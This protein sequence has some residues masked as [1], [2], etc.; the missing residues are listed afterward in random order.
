[1]KKVTEHIRDSLLKTAEILIEMAP[2]RLAVT[3]W[4][5]QFEKLMRNRL[6]MGALRYGRMC[7]PRPK[8]IT[9][10]HM[11]IIYKRLDIY[12]RTGNTEMLV[13]VANMCLVEFEIGDHPRKHFKALERE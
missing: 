10:R 11:E 4:S 13:D 12:K 3:E 5:P 1:M 2:A 8:N 6:I 7:V 9:K